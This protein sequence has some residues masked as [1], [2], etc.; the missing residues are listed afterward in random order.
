MKPFQTCIFACI[1][2]IGLCSFQHCQAQQDNKNVN[3]TPA[4]MNAATIPANYTFRILHI[5]GN[6]PGYVVLNNN[7]PA[8]VFRGTA[9]N[10]PATESNALMLTKQ[11]DIERAATLSIEKLKKGQ[12]PALSNDEIQRIANNATTPAVAN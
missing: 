6:T 3:L 5:P 8:Y 2:C 7:R 4:D 1:L 9:V 10:T 11:P 12:D